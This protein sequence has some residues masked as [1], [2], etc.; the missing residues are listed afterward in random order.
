MAIVGA[1]MVPHPPLIVSEVGQGQELVIYETCAAYR[2]VAKQIARLKPDTIVLTSP[3]TTM[4]ADYFHI[5]P[6][7]SAT[8]NFGQFGAPEVQIHAQYDRE[9]IN[10]L[11]QLLDEKNFEAGTLGERDKKLDH[12]TMVPL[13]FINQEYDKYKLVRIGLSGKSLSEHYKLGEYIKK[14]SELTN[15]RVVFVASGDLSHRLKDDG[16]YGYQKEGPM[17][18]EK[19]MGVMELGNFFELLHF[20]SSFC[21]KAGECGHKS[22]VIMAGALDRTKVLAKKLSY[23]GPFGVGYGIC[24]YQVIGADENRDFGDQFKK[25]Q[26]KAANDRQ[27]NEDAYVRLARQALES[28]IINKK[29]IEVPLDLPDEMVT[30]KAGTFVSI[31]IEGMLRGCIGTIGPTKDSIAE[32]I[33]YNAV[34]SAVHDPRFTPVCEKELSVL[35]YSVDVLGDTERIVSKDLLDV[36]RYGVIV[37]KGNRRGLLLPN[38]E[39]IDTV[40]EQIEIAKQK[41][42]IKDSE[43]ISLERFEVIRHI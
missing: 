13:Y 24:S 32:E 33:I 39:G 10:K 1:F 21:E 43:S 15:R 34:S 23:E 37:T 38:L 28:F 17:Y 29:I 20:E 42:G 4:Y 8:G 40:D 22:F 36:K 30:K 26:Q 25:E 7:I 14:T 19:I 16:P 2:E 18:D 35:T 41:A 9:F 31:K 5:S 3:H 12:A 11:V 6:G 27:V